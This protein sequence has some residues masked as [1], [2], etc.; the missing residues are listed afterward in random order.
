MR[1]G[2]VGAFGG[3][4]IIWSEFPEISSNSS[5]TSNAKLLDFLR[6]DGRYEDAIIRTERAH[7]ELRTGPWDF[8]EPSI[9][10]VK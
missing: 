9:D 1:T 5:I 3:R 7:E 4:C 10:V 8:L 6:L 2:A